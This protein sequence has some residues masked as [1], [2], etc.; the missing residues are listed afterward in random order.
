ML[1]TLLLMGGGAVPVEGNPAETPE[2]LTVPPVVE[3]GETPEPGETVA[4]PA[5]TPQ[6]PAAE[7]E[8]ESEAAEPE[9][10]LPEVNLEATTLTERPLGQEWREA[11]AEALETEIR[12]WM[13]ENREAL[14]DGEWL[15]ENAALLASL[16]IG[17]PT[18]A[19]EDFALEANQVHLLS[20]AP[21]GQRLLGNMGGVYFIH[22][23]GTGETRL[24]RADGAHPFSVEDEYQSFNA[25][26][27]ARTESLYDPTSCQWSPDGR[28]VALTFWSMVTRQVR[29]D[30]DLFLIDTREGS[31]LLAE[32]SPRKMG[33]EGAWAVLS[34]CF[35]GDS[36]TLYYTCFGRLED[37]RTS[38][39]AF[40][41]ETG[42]SSFV[43][44]AE[45]D[46]H[47]FGD[48]PHLARGPGD[49]LL[50]VADSY[51]FQSKP[52]GIYQYA[53]TAEGQWGR[54]LA[55][56]FPAGQYAA[57]YLYVS[58][59]S[60]MGLLGFLRVADQSQVF[61]VFDA[62][63]KFA[64]ADDLLVIDSDPSQ[65]Q[66][67]TVSLWDAGG[68]REAAAEALRNN[69]ASIIATAISPDG[70]QAL[71]LLWQRTEEGEPHYTMRRLN[72]R[73]LALTPIQMELEEGTEELF[74]R[75]ITGNKLGL[76]WVTGDTVCLHLFGEGRVLDFQ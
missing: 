68:D 4:E 67:A 37:A 1:M 43:S 54:K 30:M 42:E 75:S 45:D 57:R 53:R 11:V 63:D 33:E 58:E 2:L 69:E 62:N 39:W 25:L 38:L 22:E 35:S 59:Y 10:A 31:I 66:A 52:A 27:R 46:G 36:R 24:I 40:D 20:L 28:Y 60:G 74:M 29:L 70:E 13:E 21:D 7:P 44:V 9:A 8:T 51:Q 56:L 71:L 72:L 12:G 49:T 50:Q 61:S 64:G 26:M 23:L 3:P 47:R 18:I 41:M 65:E 34:A 17:D 5:D 16:G 14:D 76:E 19:P 55:H 32:T 15:G 6:L 73:T 48:M